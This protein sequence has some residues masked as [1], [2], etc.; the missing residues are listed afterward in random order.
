VAAHQLVELQV[1][2]ALLH[3]LVKEVMAVLVQLTVQHGGLV[4]AEVEPVER[5]VLPQVHQR[6]ALE[7]LVF[8]LVCQELLL[9]MRAAVLANH[10]QAQAQL[11]HLVVVAVQT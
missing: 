1:P 5:A 3:L 10:G 7:V 6:R 11:L 9:I 4:E 2:A 8:H